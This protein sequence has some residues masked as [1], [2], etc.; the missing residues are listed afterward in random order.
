MLYSVTI[1][2][3]FKLLAI[4]QFL[5]NWKKL[6][7]IGFGWKN[8]YDLFFH[9]KVGTWHVIGLALDIQQQIQVNL[10]WSSC[11]ALLACMMSYKML[12]QSDPTNGV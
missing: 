6:Y 5:Q 7:A 10:L 12:D 4:F 3:L 9:I 2:A 8:N 11:V 1:L